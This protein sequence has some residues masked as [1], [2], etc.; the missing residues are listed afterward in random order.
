MNDLE[1]DRLAARAS[2]AVRDE[3]LPHRRQPRRARRAA[4]RPTDR[5]RHAARADTCRVWSLLEARSPSPAGGAAWLPWAAALTAAAADDRRHRRGRPL[6]RLGRDHR[7]PARGDA[8]PVDADPRRRSRRRRPIRSPT[9]LPVVAPG[10]TTIADDLGD[11]LDRTVLTTFEAGDLGVE[12][13]Q[14]CEPMRPWGPVAIMSI[15]EPTIVL[16]A[17]AFNRRW[18]RVQGDDR[19]VVPF[20]DSVVVGPPVLGPD[21]LLYALVGPSFA[22]TDPRR[23]VAYDTTTLTEVASYDVDRADRERARRLER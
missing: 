13:C 4:C 14:E 2:A 7:R 21:G 11:P 8:R 5:D 6:G 19:L 10:D 15:D 22:Q 17:D 9:T 1:L 20:G 3:A 18:I 12:V 23:V 16:E